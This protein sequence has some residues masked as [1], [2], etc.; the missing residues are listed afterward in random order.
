M[1]AAAAVSAVA[2][3][4]AVAAGL[5]PGFLEFV[6]ASPSPFHAVATSAAMLERHGMLQ[7]FYSL[8]VTVVQ[9]CNQLMC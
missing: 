1:A 5:V 7:M 6:N 2:A 4:S 8:G 3:R 9:L